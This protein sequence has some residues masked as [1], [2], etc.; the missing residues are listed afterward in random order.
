MIF[1][2]PHFCATPTLSS[3]ESRGED[4]QASCMKHAFSNSHYNLT[5]LLDFIFLFLSYLFLLLLARVLPFAFDLY[6]VAFLI[7]FCLLL[8][9]MSPLLSARSF[10]LLAPHLLLAAL[11]VCF[12]VTSHC[13]FRPAK[14]S[15][16][17]MP[18]SQFVQSWT[19]N[20]GIRKVNQQ[21]ENRSLLCACPACPN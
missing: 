3:I 16:S 12:L 10:C 5:R 15:T 18:K 20:S 21:K 4:S 9:Y 8:S 17:N 1:Q 2:V 7:V 14:L 13:C 6:L 11:L 19:Q